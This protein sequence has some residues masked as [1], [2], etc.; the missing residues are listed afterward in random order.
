MLIKS[1]STR[2]RTPASQTKNVGDSSRFSVV[3]G[4]SGTLSYVWKRNGT[5]VNN[6]GDFTNAT[7]AALTI[8]PV[9]VADGRTYTCTVTGAG[10]LSWT[11]ANGVLTVNQSVTAPT[12]VG[13]TYST[14]AGLSFGFTN[15]PGSGTA[16]QRPGHDQPEHAVQ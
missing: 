6:G 3:S 5:N 11:S 9:A 1:S 8:S 7:T 15:T 12:L 14:G 4:G 16:V 10:S 13:T 2:L